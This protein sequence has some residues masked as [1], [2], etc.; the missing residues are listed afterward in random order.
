MSV[1]TDEPLPATWK[2]MTAK[3]L[4]SQ[5]TSTVLLVAMLVSMGYIAQSVIPWHMQM[6]QQGYDRNA[7]EL[8]AATAPLANS[9]DKLADRIDRVVDE[10][11]RERN[12]K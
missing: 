4:F 8:K 2:E 6:M 10:I 9:V 1:D 12:A 5:G 7:A 3:W 11:R